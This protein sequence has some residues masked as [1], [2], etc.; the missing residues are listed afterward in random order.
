MPLIAHRRDH[1]RLAPELRPRFSIISL[2]IVFAACAVAG[3]VLL[4]VFVFSVL[5]VPV[6]PALLTVMH[7]QTVVLPLGSACLLA[8]AAHRE[9]SLARDTTPGRTP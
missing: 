3:A 1:S 6:P 9:Q 8:Y 7:V 4:A 2:R 5:G